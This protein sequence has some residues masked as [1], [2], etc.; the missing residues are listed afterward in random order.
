VLPCTWFSL[1]ASAAEPTDDFLRRRRLL[2]GRSAPSTI[3]GVVVKEEGVVVVAMVVGV[4]G[5][6]VAV[7]DLRR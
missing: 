5:V 6:V 3:S 1:S 2:Q 4:V 7:R